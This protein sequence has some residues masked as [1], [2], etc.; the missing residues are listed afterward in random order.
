MGSTWHPVHVSAPE[1]AAT[2]DRITWHQECPLPST[3]L[4]G[5]WKVIEAARG[6]GVIVLLDGQ[7]ADEILGG[8]HKFM[9]LQSAVADPGA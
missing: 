8:Y 1:F 4:F 5:Q 9:A 2:W 7:G 6:A 3:S